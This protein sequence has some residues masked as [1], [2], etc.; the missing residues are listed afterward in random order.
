MDKTQIKIAWFGRHFG[1]EPP[2]VGN[3]NQGAGTIFFS[4]CHLHCVFCQ[5]YQISQHREGQFYQVKQLAD[6]MLG[7]QK[8]GAINIDL[9]SPTL[10]WQPIKQSI[11]LAKSQGLILP[12]VWNSN[13]YESVYILKELAGLIDIYLPD[14]KY[15]DENAGYKYSNIKKYPLTAIRAIKEMLNQVGQLKFDESGLATRGMIIRHLVLPNNLENSFKAL[16]MLARIDKNIYFSLM[17]QYVPLYRARE[18]NEINRQLSGVEYQ[19]VV[20]YFYEL[21]LANGWIQAG[22]SQTTL[23]PDFKKEQPF[24]QFNSTA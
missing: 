4:N 17:N 2:L 7:L 9:V 5:N 22:A 15:G 1:E 12:I 3:K 23:V 6:I 21:G 10:W 11:I 18:F 24:G 20:D 14:F 16:E 13:T 19:Q 8:S